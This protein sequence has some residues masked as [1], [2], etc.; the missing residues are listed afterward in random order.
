MIKNAPLKEELE[1]AN[2]SLNFL[3]K[4]KENL[5]KKENLD[6]K[7]TFDFKFKF[8]LG[9]DLDGAQFAIVPE[10]GFKIGYIGKI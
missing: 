3:K 8:S 1:F 2:E 9:Y 7:L 10:I 5:E 6:D 4:R